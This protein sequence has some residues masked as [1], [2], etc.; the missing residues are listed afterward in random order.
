MAKKKQREHYCRICGASKSNEAFSGKG[1]AKHICK[2]C[3]A[4]PQERKN[5]LQQINQ[6]DRIAGK[7]PR[8]KQDWEFLEKMANN[9]KYPEAMEFA[10]MI[11]GMNRSQP[12]IENDD[13]AIFEDADID[14]LPVFSEKKKFS[15]LDSYEKMVLRDYIRSE[16]T[17]HLEYVNKTPTEN[18]LIEIRKRMM[19][20]FDDEHNILLKKDVPLRKFFEDNAASIINRLQKKNEDSQ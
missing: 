8:S 20:F 10:Q 12:D 18:D 15:E 9:Q 13:D 14:C 17:E 3:S 1:H 7:Y 16:I 19:S 4:L 6:I 2:E 5:E 11:L